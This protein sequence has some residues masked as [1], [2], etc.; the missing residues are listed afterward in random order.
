MIMVKSEWAPE[1]RQS[2]YRL[3]KGLVGKLPI[4]GNSDYQ[5]TRSHQ[6]SECKMEAMAEDTKQKKSQ[7]GTEFE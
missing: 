2:A 6:G 1:R 5:L 4:R 3:V 7:E